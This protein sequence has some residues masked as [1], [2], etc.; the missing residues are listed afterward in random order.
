[1]FSF[2]LINTV[3]LRFIKY[4]IGVSNNFK[5]MLI[6]RRFSP[7]NIFT[8]YNGID[9]NKKVSN[10]SR[11]EFLNKYN[12][13]FGKEDVIIGILARLHPVK[14]IGTLLQAAKLI[15]DENPSRDL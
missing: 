3:A 13:N 7:Q 9:F 11:E 1:M 10:I 14:G 15:V 2:G 12:L 6:K 4:H 5:Q 8:V